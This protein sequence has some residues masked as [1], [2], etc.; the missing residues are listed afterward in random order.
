[1]THDERCALATAGG[2]EELHD[3]GAELQVMILAEGC[4]EVGGQQYMYM[5]MYMYM[6]YWIECGTCAKCQVSLYSHYVI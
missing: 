6:Y 2:S 4:F 1:M 3:L 5:Y